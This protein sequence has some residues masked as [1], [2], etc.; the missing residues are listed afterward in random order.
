[1]E[2]R[3]VE[4]E[5]KNHTVIA[6]LQESLKIDAIL[7]DLLVKRGINSY[8]DARNF[9]RPSLDQLHDPFLM[10]DMDLAIAR[11]ERAMQAEEKILIYGD[12]D[13]DGTTAV[14]LTFSFFK[15][16]YLV[17]ILSACVIS[18]KPPQSPWVI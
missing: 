7:A 5:V 15:W 9:F 1:M 11:I 2:K 12:Y 8:E 17:V 13:V 10:K 3:W 16:Q 18:I 4:R 14:A 6:E